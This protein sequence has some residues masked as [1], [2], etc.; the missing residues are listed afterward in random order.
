MSPPTIPS[1]TLKVLTPVPLSHASFQPYG[2][3]V[4]SPISPTLNN[5]PTSIS[6]LPSHPTAPI[7]ANQGSAVKY[8]P[9]SPIENTYGS[10]KSRLSGAPCMSMF[11]CFPRKLRPDS[12]N[13]D[14]RN[15]ISGLF[16]VQ[17]LERHPYTSQTFIPFSY[18]RDFPDSS[19]EVPVYL[20][21]VAPTLTGQT[22]IGSVESSDGSCERKSVLIHDPPDLNNLRAFLALPGQAVTYAAG[23]WHAP[24]VVLGKRRIDFLV[25]QFVNGIDEEDCQE[26]QFE[27]GVA[28]KIDE[29]NRINDQETGKAKL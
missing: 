20:V 28:V 16:D 12:D 2:T 25:V 19:G 6:S 9:I 21:I 13:K 29:T 10:G 23:T 3:A 26:V 11:S 8:S 7:L 18:G 15:K 22:A 27:K 1:P 14:K 24:M 17:I 5:A 4:A